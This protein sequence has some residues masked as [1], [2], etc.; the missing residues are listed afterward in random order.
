MKMG[1]VHQQH[2][3]FEW[4]LCQVSAMRLPFPLPR[5]RMTK[6]KRSKALWLDEAVEL[7]RQCHRLAPFRNFNGNAFA[8][9]ARQLTQRLRLPAGE[10]RANVRASP[11]LWGSQGDLGSRGRSPKDLCR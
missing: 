11:D 5:R 8:A 1:R 9:I 10:G 4:G 6:E 3:L 7:C 2:H